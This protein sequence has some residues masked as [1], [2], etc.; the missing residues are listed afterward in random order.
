[1]YAVQQVALTWFAM[2]SV[3][4]DTGYEQGYEHY[5]P[6]T[7]NKSDESFVYLNQPVVEFLCPSSQQKTSYAFR[8]V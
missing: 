1:M 5:V 7:F 3:G 4:S 6:R 2:F 8:Y